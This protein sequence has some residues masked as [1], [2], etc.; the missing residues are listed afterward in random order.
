MKKR[1]GILFSGQIRAN[2]LNPN[3]NNDDIILNSI[4]QYFLNSQKL[5]S[6]HEQHTTLLNF[7][8]QMHMHF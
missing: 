6:V 4:S 2:S 3:Y 8:I 1:V 5:G 7:E